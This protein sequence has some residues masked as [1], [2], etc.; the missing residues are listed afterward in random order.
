MSIQRARELRKSMSPPEARMWTM[1]RLPPFKALH[2]RRQM[3]IGPYYADFA[4]FRAKLV[5][6]V[7]GAQHF[8]DAAQTYD[9]RR[10][11]FIEAE[12]YRVLRF[13]TMD[14]LQYLDGVHAAILDAVSHAE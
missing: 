5:I 2:F 9:A 14:V 8:E 7:D 11:R 4:S 1:L 13:S 3:Q 6:E 10:T 12:G